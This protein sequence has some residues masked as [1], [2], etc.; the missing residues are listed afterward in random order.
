MLAHKR[1]NGERVG[2]IHYGYRLAEDG[3][4]VEPEPSEQEV[5]AAIGALRGRHRSLREVA[6]ALNDRGWRT[7]RG[8]KWRHEYVKNV[9]DK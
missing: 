3:A 1:S 5:L 9:I 7:R 2:N 6:A 4:H 8:S